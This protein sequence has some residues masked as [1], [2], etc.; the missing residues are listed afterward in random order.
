MKYIGEIINHI[1]PLSEFAL[2]QILNIIAFE[3]HQKGEIFILKGERTYNEYFVIN[4]ICN[5][6][7]QS[8]DGNEVTLSFL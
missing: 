3:S 4:G 8:P 6:F 2:Q 7:L 5:S 1:Y